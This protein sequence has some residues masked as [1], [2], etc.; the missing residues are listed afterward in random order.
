[1]VVSIIGSKSRK[2]MFI[3][4]PTSLDGKKQYKNKW[5]P[6]SWNESGTTQRTIE[7]K[8]HSQSYVEF[9][10]NLITESMVIDDYNTR[11]VSNFKSRLV[12]G[13]VQTYYT[14][15]DRFV[16]YIPTWLM[17]TFELKFTAVPVVDEEYFHNDDNP[18]SVAEQTCLL[19]H[20]QELFDYMEDRVNMGFN[21]IE[22]ALAQW[23]IDNPEYQ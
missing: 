22:P 3:V 14:M 1:M 20:E 21:S 11:N 4:N 16:V 7:W 23:E 13:K 8:H 9:P 17:R 5:I 2:S 15:I 12:D 18:T 10:Q 6:I 19:S